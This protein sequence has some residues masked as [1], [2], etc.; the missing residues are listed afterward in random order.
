[1][2]E[3]ASSEGE[4]LVEGWESREGK[5]RRWEAA[6]RK[7]RRELEAAVIGA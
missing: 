3:E 6:G 5:I 7:K 1:M 4:V 2:R